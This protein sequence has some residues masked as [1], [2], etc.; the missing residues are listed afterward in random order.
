MFLSYRGD[1]DSGYLSQMSDA[2]N[3][4]SSILKS[5]R[6]MCVI[7][8]SDIPDLQTAVKF[9]GFGDSGGGINLHPSLISFLLPKK[10][11]KNNESYF[12]GTNLLTKIQMIMDRNAITNHLN[13]LSS[14]MQQYIQSYISSNGIS[15]IEVSKLD[16]KD[17]IE[18]VGN[19]TKFT[20][21]AYN[22]DN[23][24]KVQE[25]KKSTFSKVMGDVQMVTMGAMLA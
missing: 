20:P 13:E 4:C 23:F 17:E 7:L 24:D 11:L 15:P 22:S 25:K 14:E 9:L 18:Q 12:E 8:Q 10:P 21:T 2:L 5:Y 16:I 1:A 19:F 6:I 3:S